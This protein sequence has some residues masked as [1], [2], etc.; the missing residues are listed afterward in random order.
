M[1]GCLNYQKPIDIKRYIYVGDVKSVEVETIAHFRL[2]L[3]TEYYLDL[4]DTFIVPS[5]RQN[6]VFVFV[7]DKS[8]YSCS[9]GNNKF[10]LYKNSNII[11]TG[12]LIC[13]L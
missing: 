3:G 13:Y 5:F 8:D 6:F 12:S 11:G 9:F 4:I 1:L 2:L 7:L 10:V